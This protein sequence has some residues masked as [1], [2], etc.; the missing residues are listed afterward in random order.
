VLQKD[1]GDDTAA[2]AKTITS[3]NPDSTWA[4]VE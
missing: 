3:F 2:I 1:L 4:A